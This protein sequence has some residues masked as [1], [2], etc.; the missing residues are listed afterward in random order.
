MFK[1]AAKFKIMVKK[2]S[3][4]QLNHCQNSMIFHMYEGQIKNSRDFSDNIK[5]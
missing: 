5:L 4:N 2:A 3:K 1:V